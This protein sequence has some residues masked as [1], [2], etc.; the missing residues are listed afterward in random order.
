ML[1]ESLSLSL[2]FCSAKETNKKVK[3]KPKRKEE[4]DWLNVTLLLPFHELFIISIHLSE[5]SEFVDGFCKNKKKTAQRDFISQQ[6]K[7]V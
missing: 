6:M 2:S 1:K 4:R 3:G 5:R 7:N